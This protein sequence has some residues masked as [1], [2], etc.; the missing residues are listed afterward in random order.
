MVKELVQQA[1]VQPVHTENLNSIPSTTW[2][3]RTSGCKPSGL[4]VTTENVRYDPKT[5]QVIAI[6]HPRPFL[7]PCESSISAPLWLTYVILDKVC[8]LCKLLVF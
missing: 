1:G 5:E 3:L 6:Q 8:N 2:S 7:L 4:R